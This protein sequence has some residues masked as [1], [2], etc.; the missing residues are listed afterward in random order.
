MRVLVYNTKV[1][2][3]DWPYDLYGEN[4]N[5][6]FDHVTNRRHITPDEIKYWESHS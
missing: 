1:N 6:F 2:E 3:A 4:F 5:I